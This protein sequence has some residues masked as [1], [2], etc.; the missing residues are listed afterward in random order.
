MWA[1]VV[2]ASRA[3]I[4]KCLGMLVCR[5]KVPALLD[6]L[7]LGFADLR[8]EA[9]PRRVAVMVSGLAKQQKGAQDKLRGPPA[10]VLPA[11]LDPPPQHLHPP[12]SALG[13]L[14]L[15]TCCPRLMARPHL[16]ANYFCPV[17]CL[18]APHSMLW[19]L[20]ILPWPS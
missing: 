3:K 6:R 11:R 18:R 17:G 9:T 20:F 14:C 1:R 4:I 19:G 7:R 5:A 8:I 2:T 16:P 15:M 13:A 10:K 12:A